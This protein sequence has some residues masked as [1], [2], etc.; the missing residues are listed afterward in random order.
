MCKEED[1]SII[2]YMTL[3]TLTKTIMI[4]LMYEI[5][6]NEDIIYNNM[7]WWFLFHISIHM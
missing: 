4:F 5:Q 7:I 1:T 3:F 6:K 2:I